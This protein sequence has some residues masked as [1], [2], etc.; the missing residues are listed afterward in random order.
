MT[1]FCCLLRAVSLKG[2]LAGNKFGQRCAVRITENP[3][4]YDACATSPLYPGPSSTKCTQVSTIAAPIRSKCQL[5]TC[6]ANNAECWIQVWS[7]GEKAS[8]FENGARAPGWVQSGPD[9]LDQPYGYLAP[10]NAS[11]CQV[12]ECSQMHVPCSGIGVGSRPV[13]CQ[14][15]CWISFFT[16]KPV[17]CSAFVLQPQAVRP[18]R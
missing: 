8:D 6:A 15:P 12:G 10:C 2:S 13:H 1:R 17:T 16:A 18:A 11:R 14:P 5:G 7:E 3:A 9:C 4:H